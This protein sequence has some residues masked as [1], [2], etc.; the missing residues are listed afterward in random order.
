M[1]L[2]EFKEFKSYF[3]ERYSLSKKDHN[4]IAVKIREVHWLNYG[5][6]VIGDKLIHH[7][8]E[9]WLRYSLD[10]EE[11]WKRG[12]LTIHAHAHRDRPNT[13]TLPLNKSKV[14]DPQKIARKQM[15]EPQRSY[16][17]NVKQFEDEE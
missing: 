6:G 2:S 1:K 7:P 3:P 4:G 16:Y 10:T 8:D 12:K 11:P 5:W 17:K 13:T 15:P 9:I 14:K